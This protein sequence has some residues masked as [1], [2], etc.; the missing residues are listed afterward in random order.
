[1]KV[2]QKRESHQVLAGG[3]GREGGGNH[4]PLVADHHYGSLRTPYNHP[5]YRHYNNVRQGLI[6]RVRRA[7]ESN[8]VVISHSTIIRRLLSPDRFTLHTSLIISAR[9]SIHKR[10]YARV[11]TEQAQ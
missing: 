7:P 11:Y 1:M 4:P 2:L 8:R 9:T 5:Y 3:F 10:I 6:L